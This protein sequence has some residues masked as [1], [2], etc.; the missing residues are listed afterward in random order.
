M[1][2]QQLKTQVERGRTIEFGKP[3]FDLGLRGLSVPEPADLFLNHQ[4]LFHME[5]LS[6]RNK[7]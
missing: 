1:E 7:S 3:E 2:E 6:V 5:K 4:V